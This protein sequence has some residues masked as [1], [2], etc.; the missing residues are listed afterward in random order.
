LFQHLDPSIVCGS[1]KEDQRDIL[2]LGGA[3]GAAGLAALEAVLEAARD[4]LEV[5][6]AAGADSLSALSLF[7]PVVYERD[8][9]LQPSQKSFVVRGKRRGKETYTCES[10]R[11]G[12]RKKRTPSSGRKESGD[13][14]TRH[15][16][17]SENGFPCER[18][19]ELGGAEHVSKRVR[20]VGHAAAVVC[21][22][23]KT[24]QKAFPPPPP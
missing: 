10:W 13:L 6:R 12:S 3:T 4:I 7:A 19:R 15:V 9:Q 11:W 17:I 24:L 20:S 5:A 14:E 2:L 1:D 18:G 23:S 21:I 22:Y 16:S 8:C